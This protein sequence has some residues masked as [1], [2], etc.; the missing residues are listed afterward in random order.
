[1]QALIEAQSDAP[2][3][4]LSNWAYTKDYLDLYNNFGP[5][6]ILQLLKTNQKDH[7][8]IAKLLS[9]H[10]YEK[11]KVRI[12]P[13]TGKIINVKGDDLVY[14]DKLLNIRRSCGLLPVKDYMDDI[15]TKR[16]K[17]VDD[18][19][20]FGDYA[21]VDM[22]EKTVAII[23]TK[24][25]VKA[26]GPNFI[27]RIENDYLKAQNLGVDYYLYLAWPHSTRLAEEM[28]ER[29][30][31]RYGE[32][33]RAYKEWKK[34]FICKKID[35]PNNVFMA[36]YHKQADPISLFRLRMLYIVNEVRKRCNTI[37]KS[38]SFN[39]TP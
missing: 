5:E 18:K 1:M 37:Y 32:F 25:T 2:S 38:S 33:A 35:M 28:F 34:M 8:Q 10:S 19:F 9:E 29:E 31:L 3:N 15:H 12:S 36:P 39:T 13:I 21:I 24:N 4:P 17:D 27:T 6:G 23:E 16:Y 20:G 30:G 26:M 7:G 22:L 11:L 14:L